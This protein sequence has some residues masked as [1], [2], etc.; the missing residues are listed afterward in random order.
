MGLPG[1]QPGSP[2]FFELVINRIGDCLKA[3][4]EGERP[5]GIEDKDSLKDIT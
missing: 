2:I 1:K 5:G 4:G 3:G